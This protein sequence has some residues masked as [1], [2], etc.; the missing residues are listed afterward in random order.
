MNIAD[1]V[2]D[3]IMH[4]H[5]REGKRE[6]SPPLS[7]SPSFIPQAD[8]TISLN[9]VCSSGHL[10]VF[11]RYELIPHTRQ[12]I[13]LAQAVPG[14]TLI[15]QWMEDNRGPIGLEEDTK[16]INCHRAGE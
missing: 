14:A 8:N 4:K 9:I 16:L 15:N 7:R 12:S 6:K 5:W 13:T 1:W 2:D 10:D 3:V 11:T